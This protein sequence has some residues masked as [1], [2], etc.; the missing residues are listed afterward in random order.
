MQN[1]E[2]KNRSAEQKERPK[3]PYYRAF[4]LLLAKLL[5]A[6]EALHLAKAAFAD[7]NV[8]S[9]EW[10]TRVEDRPFLSGWLADICDERIPGSVKHVP[11]LRVTDVSEESLLRAAQDLKTQSNLWA[12]ARSFEAFRE[13]VRTIDSCLA[14]PRRPE[15]DR[16]CSLAAR[17]L[18]RKRK[19]AERRF[20]A[21]LKR[22]RKAAPLLKRC[23][24]RN[25]RGIHLAQWICV[26]AVVR[27]AVAHNEGILTVD[28]YK[29]YRSSNLEKEFPGDLDDELGY[30]L[31]PGADVTLK[32]IQRLR[33][34]ALVIYKTVSEAA[35]LPTLIY[36]NEKGITTWRR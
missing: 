30:V 4:D 25:A 22:V 31:T 18:S 16:L 21:A 35:S 29:K 27:N 32:T 13:F 33:E 17:F 14:D 20:D 7:E 36:D 34:Y 9:A 6:E 12:I 19:R 15:V 8:S 26:V 10:A 11:S 28:K 2:S 1:K 23:E 3:N 24:T 5:A